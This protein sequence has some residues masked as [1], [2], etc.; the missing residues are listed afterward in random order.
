MI[1]F[2]L[3]V[4]IALCLSSLPSY[5]QSP[6]FTVTAMSASIYQAPSA[7]SPVI[8]Q[9]SEGA[10]LDVRG[11]LAGWIEVAWP[12]AV[13]GIAY[14]RAAT[15][16]IEKPAPN[17][18]ATGVQRPMTI[19]EFVHGTSTAQVPTS[20]PTSGSPN[21]N[22][23]ATGVQRPMTIDEFVRGTSV[24]Q[25]PPTLPAWGSPNPSAAYVAE[26]VEA[27][28]AASTP[29]PNVTVSNA[30]Y[31]TPAHFVGLGV[32]IGN[33][34]P[35]VGATGRVW[36]GTGVGVQFEIFRDA[37]TNAAT[38]ERVISLQFAP[39]VLYALP[40]EVSDYFWV[41]PYLGGGATIDRSTLR[42]ANPAEISSSSDNSLGLQLFGGGEVTFAG[43]PRFALSADV[44][45]RKMPTGFAG[46]ERRKI[47]FALSGHWFVR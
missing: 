12:N 19:D 27:V 38:A 9:S 24:A 7:G 37:R 5:A 20:L 42:S 45:Y 33:L 32:R 26:A 23:V 10:V 47:R 6:R 31:V 40:N 11:E 30:T 29:R 39:S 25:V 3:A 21:P 16:R 46:F 14:V 8:G 35:S 2:T 22:R 13:K 43:I 15:G 4:A 36:A 17:R 18:V 44:G 41:R 1:R 34:T 28:S